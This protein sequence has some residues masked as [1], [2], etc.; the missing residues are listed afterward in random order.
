[1]AVRE[2]HQVVLLREYFVVKFSDFFEIGTVL[3]K[4]V[5][6]VKMLAPHVMIEHF[7]FK[8]Q[9]S[10][11]LTSK[12]IFSNRKIHETPLLTFRIKKTKR[13]RRM[14]RTWLVQRIARKSATFVKQFL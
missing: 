9:L 7:D 11:M 14:S 2:V 10:K 13:M 12:N 1:M 5:E 4:R 3:K 8:I 6:S